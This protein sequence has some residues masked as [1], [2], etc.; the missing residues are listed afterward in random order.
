MLATEGL[1]SVI[2]QPNE[3]IIID[4]VHNNNPAQAIKGKHQFS[5]EE[6]KVWVK[7]DNDVGGKHNLILKYFSQVVRVS[8]IAF[9]T[10]SKYETGFD[11]FISYMCGGRSIL[12]FHDIM[13]R[14]NLL[15]ADV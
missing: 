10:T 15:L 14:A 9:E 12:F 13:L 7:D 3:K 4:I 1:T 11:G 5:V 8:F 2:P 6:V